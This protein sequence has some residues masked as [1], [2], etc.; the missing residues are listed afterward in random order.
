MTDQEFSDYVISKTI[1]RIEFDSRALPIGKPVVYMALADDVILYVGMSVHGIER[2]F[3]K[4]HHVLSHI[5][6]EIKTF[7]VYETAT[8]KDARDLE[9]AMIQEFKPKYNDRQHIASIRNCGGRSVAGR[10]LAR[11]GF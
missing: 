4:G 1:R 10:V 6:S 8:E 11:A 3:G 5:H 2:V 9:A 7:E